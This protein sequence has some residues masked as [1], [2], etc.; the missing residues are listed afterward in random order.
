MFCSNCGARVNTNSK[1]CPNCGFQLIASGQSAPEQQMAPPQR[2][3]N[4][5]GW[6]AQ[7]ND[8]QQQAGKSVN[9][10]GSGVMG[11]LGE[12]QKYVDKGLQNRTRIMANGH[13]RTSWGNN[14]DESRRAKNRVFMGG[15]S[16]YRAPEGKKA[17]KLQSRNRPYTG[18]ERYGVPQPGWSDRINDPEIRA[19]IK[20]TRG[21][22]KV[23]AFFA[24]PLPF[25]G[26][27]IY[28]AVSGEMEMSTAFGGGLF[29]SF[30]FLICVLAGIWQGSSK[31]NYEGMVVDKYEQEERD[32]DADGGSFH[33][34]LIGV[35]VVRTT[36]GKTKKIKEAEGGG[37]AWDY[38]EIGAQ[39]RYHAEM[40]GFPYE[41]Y[42][43]AKYPYLYCVAC[44]TKTP[45][46][47][48][49]CIRCGLPLL[50]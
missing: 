29:V 2:W 28:A 7:S 1:F 37:L 46:E 50:K 45:I 11:Y 44:R 42:D 12:R 33:G 14:H 40:P 49:R 9:T 32:N 18:Y 43:K 39:F 25:I 20:K 26:F 34:R 38:L 36:D 17:E 8:W 35:T 13:E 23:A 41:R 15:Q 22:G 4:N 24:V 21:I 27:I 47:E 48:D 5:A 19:A 16:R 6:Q 10:G 30:V 31:R 3:V